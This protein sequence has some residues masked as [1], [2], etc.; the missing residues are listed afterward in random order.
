MAMLTHH[1]VGDNSTVILTVTASAAQYRHAFEHEV[2]HATRGV[3]V[4]GFRPGFAPKEKVIQEVGQVKLEA[5]TLEHL[6][7][8]TFGEASREAG[9]HI[10]GTPNISI[11]KFTAP[12]AEA[13]NDDV[14]MTYKATC[15]V[16]PMPDVTGYEKMKVAA[17][18]PKAIAQEQIDEVVGQLRKNVASLE[19]LPETTVAANGMW[20]DIGYEGT[21]D[22]V[23]RSD[24]KNDHHPL[25]IGENTLIPGFEEHIVGLK[26]GESVTFPITFPADYGVATLQNVTAEFTITLHELREVVLPE[27]SDE[28]AERFGHKT[29]D[30]LIA[31][32]RTNMEEEAAQDARLGLEDAVVQELLKGRDTFALP[33]TLV[34]Q[35]MERLFQEGKQQ[36]MRVPGQWE[37]YLERSGKTEDEMRE[38]LREQSEKNIRVGALLVQVARAE[39]IEGE[40]VGR[41]ALDRLVAIATA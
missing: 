4:K 19:E 37:L 26:K 10:V 21:V 25:V 16:V 28:I 1:E 14:V 39:D 6:I 7:N 3:R 15:E 2:E 32:I 36:L 12:S 22:K 17:V 18:A 27:L 33:K 34:E 40:T 31:A 20:A 41:L 23:P 35:E 38:E 30:E 29:V 8:D 24:M 5:A 13:D 11:E 9:A